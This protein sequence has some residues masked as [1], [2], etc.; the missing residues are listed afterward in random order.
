MISFGHEGGK[1]YGYVLFVLAG[2]G[3]LAA[4]LGIG[5]AIVARTE[6]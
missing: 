6:R 5:T 3:L 2:G 1:D 4:I